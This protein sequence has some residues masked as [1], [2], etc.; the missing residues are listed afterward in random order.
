MTDLAWL[1]IAEASTLLRERKLSP[2]EYVEALY[3]RSDRYDDRFNTYLCVT[4]D[5]AMRE[6]KQAQEEIARGGL[7][8]LVS[9]DESI[10]VQGSNPFVDRERE[11]E[12]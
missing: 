1:T 7:V 2:V 3:A 11:T 10:D 8:P 12:P 5:I 4:R 9:R 6:A